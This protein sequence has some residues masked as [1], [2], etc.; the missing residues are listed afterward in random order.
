MERGTRDGRLVGDN[1]VGV[2]V[3]S[4]HS[5]RGVGVVG[6]ALNGLDCD[7]SVGVNRLIKANI[8]CR[9]WGW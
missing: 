4:L 2:D 9:V 7:Y 3:I 5:W 6:T 1:A 8:G